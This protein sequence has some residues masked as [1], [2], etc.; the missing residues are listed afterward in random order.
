MN[1]TATAILSEVKELHNVSDRLN[2][3]AGL[4]PPVSESLIGISGSVRN[5]ATLLE[6]LIAAKMTQIPGSAPGSA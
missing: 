4:H 2:M 5:C 3:I 1:P 6:V